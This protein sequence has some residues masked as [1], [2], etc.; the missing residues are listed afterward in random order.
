MALV[1]RVDVFIIVRFLLLLFVDLLQNYLFHFLC[2][3][4]IRG[5]NLIV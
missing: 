2:Q 3:V 5:N 4:I 1:I